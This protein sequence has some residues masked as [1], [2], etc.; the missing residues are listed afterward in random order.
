MAIR[1]NIVRGKARSAIEADAGSTIAK[2]LEL[3][4]VNRETVLVRLNGDVA[5]EEEAVEDGD[6][7]EVITAVSGG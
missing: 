1:I 7:V 4:G 6:V 5:I 3:I 2:V